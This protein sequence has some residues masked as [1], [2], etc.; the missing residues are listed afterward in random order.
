MRFTPLVYRVA[1]RM[2]SNKQEAED[3]SQETFIRV[4]RS[5]DGF[6]AT[7]SLAPW[8]AQ[9][10]YHVCLKRLHKVSSESSV[11]YFGTELAEIVDQKALTDETDGHYSD[12]E[13][14]VN[15]LQEQH[16]LTDSLN[17]LAAQDRLLLDLR[18]REG[19]S[20]TELGQVTGIP[21][22][23][24]KTRIFRARSFLRKILTSKIHY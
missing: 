22:N 9:I 3:A 24:V 15:D 5:L 8:I 19:L 2:V 23:T 1:Y 7:R 10:T 20:D 11:D 4:Y 12:P 17:Q 18:Y 6:D 14:C 21:V 16:W 13:K